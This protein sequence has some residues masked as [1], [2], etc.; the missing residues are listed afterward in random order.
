MRRRTYRPS[1]ISNTWR[2]SKISWGILRKDR[3]LLVIPVLML[4]VCA[5]VITISIVVQNTLSTTSGPDAEDPAI[6]VLSVTTSLVIGVICVFL[7]GALVAGAYE[8]MMG[9]DPTVG[10]ALSAA[11]RRADRLIF[12]G[13]ITTT[14]GIL[15]RALKAASRRNQIFALLADVIDTAWDVV[16]F[17]TVPAIVIDGLGPIA[18]FKRS[19][20]LLRKTWGENLAAQVGFGWIAFF[21]SIPGLAITVLALNVGLS[22]TAPLAI[23]GFGI[24]ITWII[25]VLVFF[26]ALNSVYQA[27]LYV[28]ATANESTFEREGATF[29]HTNDESAYGAYGHQETS[30]TTPW[31]PRNI[32]GS[33]RNP[34]N[35]MYGSSGQPIRRNPTD[36][37]RSAGFDSDYLAES[38]IQK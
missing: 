12:W 4:L 30:A 15:L 18:G 27:A 38:F 35:P 28:Y 3:E 26:I 20:S 13:L 2:L 19:S 33:H 5:G 1:K 36:N 23:V 22:W 25:I 34:H 14:V 31:M 29:G 6:Q 17:L 10:S 9:G 32:G 7:Q 21:L 8:R 37:L 16:T 11:M 24:G